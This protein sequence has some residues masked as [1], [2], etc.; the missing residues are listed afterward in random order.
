MNQLKEYK[1]HIIYVLL[2]IIIVLLLSKGK[3]GRYAIAGGKG[4][5]FILD[6]KTSQLWARTAKANAYWG[7]NENPMLELI[8]SRVKVE[9]FEEIGIKSDTSENNK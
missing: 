3:Q 9:T 5:V 2:I 8:S 7:T 1:H 6:T 4:V